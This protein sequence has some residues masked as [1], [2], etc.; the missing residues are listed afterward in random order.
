[1]QTLLLD[2]GRYAEGLEHLAGCQ[3]SPC[4]LVLADKDNWA[5][6]DWAYM[7]QVGVLVLLGDGCLLAVVH[8]Q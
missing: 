1:M 5:P 8:C 4:T 2:R 3:G 7:W 6:Q